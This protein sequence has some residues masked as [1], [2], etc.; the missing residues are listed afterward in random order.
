ME[1]VLYLSG[2]SRIF[3]FF[4]ILWWSLKNLNYTKFNKETTL[5]YQC[6]KKKKYTQIHEILQFFVLA[7]REKIRRLIS[8]KVENKN[9]KQHDLRITRI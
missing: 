1:I 8:D 5:I 9:V 6:H 4:F 3:L 2:G 7:K